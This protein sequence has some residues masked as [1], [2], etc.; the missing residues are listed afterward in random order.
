MISP[1]RE[2]GRVKSGP[3]SGRRLAPDAES[4]AGGEEPCCERYRQSERTERT[5]RPDTHATRKRQSS[6]TGLSN[7]SCGFS[8]GRVREGDTRLVCGTAVQ[9]FTSLHFFGMGVPKAEVWGG[10]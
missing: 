7:W 10:A 6:H 4:L 9:D 2:A 8:G 1:K 5:G 3:V